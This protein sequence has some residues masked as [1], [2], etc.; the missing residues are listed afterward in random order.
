MI[1]IQWSGWLI[2]RG[3]LIIS[4]KRT[5]TR[6][7]I[8]GRTSRLQIWASGGVKHMRITSITWIVQE[9]S[10]TRDGEMHPYIVLPWDYSK[11]RVRSIGKTSIYAS[12]NLW[13]NWITRFRDIGYQH[14]PYFNCPNS[15]KCKGCIAARF[16][17]GESW[18][19]KEDCRPNWF[20]YVGMGWA[21]L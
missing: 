16:T 18:L 2:A 10:S 12:L 4:R 21:G 8:F 9:D 1:R 14:I 6:R 7:V 15:P 11:T 19:L 5:V 13:A 3:D 20:K 17:D